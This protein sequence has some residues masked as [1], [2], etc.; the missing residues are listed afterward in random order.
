MRSLEKRKQSHARSHV[1]HAHKSHAYKETHRD[2][3]THAGNET[4]THGLIRLTREHRPLIANRNRRLHEM[5]AAAPKCDRQ[6]SLP[7]PPPPPFSSSSSFAFHLFTTTTT[8]TVVVVII[9]IIVVVVIIVVVI[10]IIIITILHLP[11]L[12]SDSSILILIT[13]ISF[14]LG[15]FGLF[16]RP[17]RLHSLKP[18]LSPGPIHLYHIQFLYLLFFVFLLF[19][20]IFLLLFLHLCLISSPYSP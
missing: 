20:L 2:T 5:I 18:R 16:L 7:P 10:I 4:Y 1:V 6:S 14:S 11:L 13:A 8:T 12:P 15:F 9:I 3:G 17:Y 19:V